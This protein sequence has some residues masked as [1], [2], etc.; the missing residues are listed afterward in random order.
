[1][2]ASDSVRVELPGKGHN[3]PLSS[4]RRKTGLYSMPERA[5]QT[6]ES[7]RR[8]RIRQRFTAV[9]NRGVMNQAKTKIQGNVERYFQIMRC[10][11]MMTKCASGA[12]FFE[13]A[14]TL[15]SSSMAEHPAVN[16]RVV[17]SSPT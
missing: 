9:A 10:F 12:R 15:L 16:R 7:R 17:G 3:W 13:G 8:S 5:G 4:L 1:M 2:A 11:D 6:L 14:T